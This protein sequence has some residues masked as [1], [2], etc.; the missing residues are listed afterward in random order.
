[1]SQASPFG[2]PFDSSKS[3]PPAGRDPSDALESSADSEHQSASGSL[4]TEEDLLLQAGQI[5]QHVR[6]RSVELEQLR[7]QLTAAEDKLKQRGDQLDQRGQQLDQRSND[8]DQRGHELDERSQRLDQERADF[9][10]RRENLKAE[11]FAELDAERKSLQD[12][13]EA[14]DRQRAELSAEQ[15]RLQRE[16]QQVLDELRA[17]I[18]AERETLKSQVAADVEVEYAEQLTL[19]EA[20]KQ[21]RDREQAEIEQQRLET[22]DF[23]DRSQEELAK[24]RREQS[25]RLENE[26][27][28]H[29]QKLLSELTEVS[30]ERESK[31][32]QLRQEETVLKNRLRFQFDHL[33]AARKQLEQELNTL[34][35][36]QQ[37]FRAHE[38]QARTLLMLRSRQLQYFRLLLE[39][40]EQSVERE[41]RL[42]S[43]TRAN[44]DR[45]LL[46][47]RE[48][49][50][51]EQA[52]WKSEQELQK[53][54][55]ERQREL[56][57]QHAQNL[58]TRKNRLEQLRQELESTHRENLEIRMAVEEAWAQMAQSTDEQFAQQRV[59][60]ARRG[61][62]QHFKHLHE[63]IEQQRR[64]LSEAQQLLDQQKAEFREERQT[65]TI[66]VSERDEAI[67]RREEQLTERADAVAEQQDSWH[68]S[69]DRWVRE[70]TEAEEIIRGLLL[71]LSEANDPFQ[72]PSGSLPEEINKTDAMPFGNTS[73]VAE[74]PADAA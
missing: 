58:D 67:R 22:Q 43:K 65:L 51:V 57:N 74:P 41:Q 70:R 72:P 26:R 20:W 66:W 44:Q 38:E 55:L 33:T 1:M 23:I 35:R 37:K 49:L 45:E 17:E 69:R 61:L 63:T 13:R 14:A 12:A 28:E 24:S 3:D 29:E 25:E 54:E 9:E 32:E 6:K 53:A 40:R 2:L 62:S 7:Q 10:R 16:Q 36:D 30:S 18:E 68:Q 48:H 64:E 56:L 4:G 46:K 47:E 50:R 73:A 11:L 39:E 60:D 34:N 42:L 8:L 71:Q 15:Q 21:Q 59:E 31:L 52:A 27:R 19:I 5:V